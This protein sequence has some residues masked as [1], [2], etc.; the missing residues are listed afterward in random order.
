MLEY[1]SVEKR[2]WISGCGEVWYRAW[3]GFKR[4]RVR[5]STL[6][7]R[8]EF[9]IVDSILFACYLRK[10][11]RYRLN[12]FKLESRHSDPKVPLSYENGT[13]SVIWK[14]LVSI[15]SS[16]TYSITESY[17]AKCSIIRIV[18]YNQ[19]GLFP[20]AT[21]LKKIF[22]STKRMQTFRGIIFKYYNAVE[23]IE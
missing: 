6:G 21:F 13:F 8:M 3:M 5:I 9:T 2:N 11:S 12:C 18:P 4:P 1:S 10:N 23:E 17:Y 22:K 14:S 15:W 19:I 20:C 7:P 16:R